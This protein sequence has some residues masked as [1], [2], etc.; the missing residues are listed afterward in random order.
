MPNPIRYDFDPTG[1]LSEMGAVWFIAYTYYMSVDE[2]ELRWKNA[3]TWNHRE[4]LYR[5]MLMN[6]QKFGLYLHNIRNMKLEK[7][8]NSLGIPY[9]ELVE[10]QKKI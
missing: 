7:R 3:R 4:Q 9:D 6:P 8:K 10:M 5:A 1:E 2:N